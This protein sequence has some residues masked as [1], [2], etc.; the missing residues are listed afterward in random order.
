MVTIKDLSVRKL[1]SRASLS[2]DERAK[3]RLVSRTR[4]RPHGWPSVGY[5]PSRRKSLP[6][7]EFGYARVYLE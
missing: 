4:D 5:E 1:D 2:R 6:F 7:D 3:G